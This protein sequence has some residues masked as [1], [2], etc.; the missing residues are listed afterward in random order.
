ML[1]NRHSA[2]VGI[3]SFIVTPLAGTNQFEIVNEGTLTNLPFP[4]V[5][6]VLR[7][8]EARS[9]SNGKLWEKIYGFA[10]GNV[11]EITSQDGNF[12]T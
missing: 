11:K 4:E 9:L 2:K 6:I 5:I 8:K 3:N 12:D 7:E 10:D 1:S